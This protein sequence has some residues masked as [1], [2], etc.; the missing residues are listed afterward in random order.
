MI[1]MG[2]WF[3]GDEDKLD[4]LP[5]AQREEKL[6][7][8]VPFREVYIHALVRD[9]DRQ[10]MSK[11]KG[12]VIDPIEIIERFGTDAVRF[13]LASMAAPGTD[14][15]FNEDRTEGYRAFANK[16]WNAARFIFMNVDKAQQS[17]AWSAGEFRADDAPQASTL[18]D[19]WILSRFHA[20]TQ[21]VN[22]AL[23]AYRFDEAANAVYRFFWNEFC[24]WYVEMVKLR[25]NAGESGADKATTRAALAFTLHIF[26]GSLRLLSPFMPFITEEI[27]HAVYDGKAP[28]KSIALTRYPTADAILI[29]AA[30]EAEMAL[31]QSFIVDVRTIRAEMK[32]ENKLK[33]PVETQAKDGIRKTL[34]QNLNS[35]QKLA[36]A[37]SLAF[38]DDSLANFARSK[39]SPHYEVRVVYEQK[40]DV[41]AERERLTKELT[42]L[43]TERA[44]AQRQL[45]NENFMAKASAKV[46]EGVKRREGELAALIA[47]LQKALNDLD[48]APSK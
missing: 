36:N 29:S 4:A 30:A 31:L 26:E 39:V 20:V 10:K 45:S 43:Q 6:K 48:S 23:N 25:L 3:M 24:D 42:K 47:K 34:E 9:A 22:D 46:V 27:W 5:A 28:A 8:S 7:A 12:N 21:Q 41:A 40:I 13:T 14:I 35:I 18:E 44:N 17:G 19:R 1:M 33:T 11:T 32:V 16:I 37:E 38:T 2:C 15:A